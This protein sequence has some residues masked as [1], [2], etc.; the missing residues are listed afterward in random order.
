M[1][2]A[3]LIKKTAVR[4]NSPVVY[5]GLVRDL[6]EQI[7]GDVLPPG[8]QMPS[9]NLLTEQYG[10]SRSSVRMALNEL[11]KSG[12][13]IKRPGKGSFVCDR[14][15]SE[16]ITR[17]INIGL[18]CSF[19]IVSGR[20]YDAMVIDGVSSTCNG[21]RCRTNI[22]GRAANIAELKKNYIEGLILT[23]YNGR[24]EDLSVLTDSGIEVILFNRITTLE[25]LA[26]VAV[27]YHREAMEAVRFLRD[28]GH[29]RI[30]TAFVD[31]N[32]FR[33]RGY[34]DALGL[35]EFPSEY[36]IQIE[37]VQADEYYTEKIEKCLRDGSPTAFYLT[38]GSLAIPF[39]NAVE[40]LKLRV[41]EDIEMICFDDIAY[42]YQIYKK[43]FSYVK[44][45]LKT[46][47]SE[48]A[49]YLCRKIENPSIPVMKKLYR[50][51]IV[52]VRKGDY[53]N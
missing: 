16:K 38:N 4:K 22:I 42:L 53:Q 47:G 26:Y 8:A 46:M 51:E 7:K 13:I 43:S 21:D 45:P 25:N 3:T 31:T 17:T 5:A 50:A 48:A 34:L 39:F 10:I 37:S 15:E 6:S 11:E 14:F 49:E 35:T 52:T 18:N 23:Q 29:Q 40:R 19:E 24:F 1:N 27:N 30:G 41:P 2:N 28:R 33:D 20:W 32:G 12:L 36:T 44:M 9:E